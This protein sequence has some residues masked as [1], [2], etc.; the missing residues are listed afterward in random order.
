M[1]QRTAVALLAVLALAGCGHSRAVQTSTATRSM[2][3]V[4]TRTVT[5]TV[6]SAGAPV[7]TPVPAPVPAPAR[8]LVVGA[9][10]DEAKFAPTDADARA[11]MAR[12]RDAGF[13]AIAF[14]AFWRP[15]LRELPKVERDALRRAARA[16]V[17]ASIT[18]IVDVAQFG[19]DTP[20]TD[21]EREEFASFAASV[22]RLVPQVDHVVVGNEP[23][24]N[25]FW[26]PQFD[27][28]G[29]DVAAQ[30]YER[31]LARSYDAI[32]AVA[33]NVEVIGGGLAARGADRPLGK[34]PT[35]S[36]TAFIRDLGDAYRASGRSLPLMDAFS[37]HVYG[38]SSRV[39]PTRPHPLSSTIGI[40]DYD[41]L[42]RLLREALGRATPVVY[43]EYGVNTTIPPARKRPIPAARST[44]SIRSTR[45]R[46]PASTRRRSHSRPAS[47]SSRCSSSSTSRTSPNSSTSRPACITPTELRNPGSIRWRRPPTPRLRGPFGARAARAATTESRCVEA[48]RL[49]LR[50]RQRPRSGN[51]RSFMSIE[52]A[53]CDLSGGYD[54]C[55]A[56]RSTWE[57]WR[58]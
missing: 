8:R 11:H 33:P 45:R 7:P 24:T 29:G 13:R 9:V 36:P 53:F 51:A 57:F 47:R 19:G 58:M 22:P 40:A 34:R 6:P 44:R 56:Q 4:V 1:P 50:Q 26:R 37:V 20:L 15:P 14:S 55:F 38:E 54:A 41:R 49:C 16:A 21:A 28:S 3:T 23:N 43:G 12:A 18:P 35:H 39:P 30:A 48:R 25:L 46:R 10:E 27:A 31:L 42:V 17:A 5:T 2:T 52:K 32:K